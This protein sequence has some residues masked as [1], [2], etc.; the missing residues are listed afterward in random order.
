MVHKKRGYY[1]IGG[2]LIA[3]LGAINIVIIGYIY[4][5]DGLINKNSLG[6]ILIVNIILIAIGLLMRYFNKPIIVSVGNIT[7]EK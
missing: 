1:R 5:M 2:I 4:A 3:I 6:V 7:K